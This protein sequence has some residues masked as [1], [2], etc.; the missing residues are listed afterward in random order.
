MPDANKILIADDHPARREITWIRLEESSIP[1]SPSQCGTAEETLSRIRSYDYDLLVT[2][3]RFEEEDI[4]GIRLIDE[5]G[6]KSVVQT[7]YRARYQF[8]SS[9]IAGA[10][11]YVIKFDPMSELLKAV[12]IVLN[13]GSYYSDKAVSESVVGKNDLEERHRNALFAMARHGTKQ[14]AAEELGISLQSLYNYRTQIRNRLGLDSTKQ[15]D[16]VAQ[17]FA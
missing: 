14:S 3:L 5:N 13:G 17:H 7:Q 10:D 1:V 12:R 2:D 16:R 8:Q 4:G 9:L 15:V 6:G 11:G